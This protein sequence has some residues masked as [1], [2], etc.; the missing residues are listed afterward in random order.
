MTIIKSASGSG[1]SIEITTHANDAA[2]I[3]IEASTPKGRRVIATIAKTELAEALKGA[4]MYVATLNDA[5]N[6][7]EKLTNHLTEENKEQQAKL[8]AIES[9]T[10]AWE[11]FDDLAESAA[12]IKAILH[13]EPPYEFP[14]RKGAVI[15]A[16]WPDGNGYAT[17]SRLYG[18]GKSQAVWVRHSN[19]VATTEYAIRRNAKNFRT[20]YEGIDE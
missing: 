5:Q 15:E 16:E 11:G 9:L 2:T 18:D 8:D 1:N 20:I 14:T 17:Y 19:G 6:A 3:V 10:S 4:G 7:F 12:E 13:P